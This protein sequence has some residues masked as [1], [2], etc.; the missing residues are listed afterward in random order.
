MQSRMNLTNPETSSLLCSG[1]LPEHRTQNF[2]WGTFCVHAHRMS[3][4]QLVLQ[5]GILLQSFLHQSHWYFQIIFYLFQLGVAV[6]SS[7]SVRTWMQWPQC[8]HQGAGQGRCERADVSRCALGILLLLLQDSEQSTNS[9][10]FPQTHPRSR[11]Q[12]EKEDTFYHSQIYNRDCPE[13][14]WIFHSQ[15]KARWIS[16][17]T[18]LA[19]G[20]ARGGGV[21]TSW[22]FKFLPTHTILGF[23]VSSMSLSWGA[24]YLCW[25]MLL[26]TY[27]TRNN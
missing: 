4:T 27:G 2:C 16:E 11:S 21:G 1:E 7:R 5:A 22:S 24:A 8:L 15:K 17:Q 23:C 25:G 6:T 19:E 13:K 10:K 12:V 3:C 26:N 20:L 14:L 9:Q 18:G